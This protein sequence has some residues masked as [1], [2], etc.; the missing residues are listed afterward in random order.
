LCGVA[1]Q[2]HNDSTL[3]NSLVDL[4]KVLAGHPAVL[5]GLLPGLPV[6]SHTDDY[7]EAVVAEVKTLTVTL[8][9]VTDE[10]EGV[11]LE[12]LLWFVLRSNALLLVFHGRNGLRTRSLSL[13]QSS[14]SVSIPI[15]SPTLP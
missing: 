8:G 12:V 9:S 10:G 4:E 3:A 1:E 11:V 6:L 14:R 7:V 13:G 15:V 2:V 5:L